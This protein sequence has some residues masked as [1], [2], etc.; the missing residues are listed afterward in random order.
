M[1]ENTPG[2]LSTQREKNYSKNTSTN[3]N[4]RPNELVVKFTRISRSANKLDQRRR[5]LT[6]KKAE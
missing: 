5:K 1:M 2:S 3:K 6:E 4:D